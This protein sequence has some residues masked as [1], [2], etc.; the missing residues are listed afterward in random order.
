MKWIYRGFSVAGFVFEYVL[1]IILFGK[2]IPYTHGEIAAGLTAAGVIAVCILAI[3]V[4]KRIKESV[5][6]WDHGLPRGIV[7]SL[8]EAVPIVLVALFLRWLAPAISGILEYWLSIIP[9]F[10]VGR[11]FYIFAEIV[12]EKGGKSK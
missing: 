6:R 2:V 12:Y 3:V 9:F 11:L 8:I 10:I 5:I 1:P 7:L 4:A